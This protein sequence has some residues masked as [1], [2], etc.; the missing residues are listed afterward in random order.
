MMSEGRLQSKCDS[1]L[2]VAPVALDIFD[3]ALGHVDRAGNV[4]K[5]SHPVLF[6]YYFFNTSRTKCLMPG[7]VHILVLD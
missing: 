6:F 5:S 4:P 3:P 7:S 2:A 1:H